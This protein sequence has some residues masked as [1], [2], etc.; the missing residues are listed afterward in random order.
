MSAKL[1][2]IEAIES[3]HRFLQQDFAELCC[4][5]AVL[6]DAVYG[7]TNIQTCVENDAMRHNIRSIAET[8][9]S[10]DG[11]KFAI[12]RSTNALYIAIRGS[13]NIENW[14]SN[15]MFNSPVLIGSRSGKIHQG[16]WDLANKHP[17]QNLIF[18]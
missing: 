18:C 7:N 14:K 15:L 5:A 13:D 11:L 17:T 10:P 8:E 6:N 3:N 1:P 9:E 16:F 2:A 12:A 4:D